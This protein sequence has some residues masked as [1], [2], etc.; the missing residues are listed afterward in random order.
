MSRWTWFPMFVLNLSLLAHNYWSSDQDWVI[1]IVILLFSGCKYRP[2]I[3]GAEVLVIFQYWPSG[4]EP[5]PEPAW[6][7]MGKCQMKIVRTDR[8]NCTICIN[9]LGC[10]HFQ[11]CCSQYLFTSRTL[12]FILTHF[13]V[14]I[15]LIYICGNQTE[16]WIDM[17][18]AKR[19]SFR[20]I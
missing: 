13:S 1:I 14:H 20:I 9:R 15:Q 3:T 7:R 4:G 2:L 5:E 16:T 8:E 12:T 6:A 17:Y 19:P 11:L 18:L 10:Y